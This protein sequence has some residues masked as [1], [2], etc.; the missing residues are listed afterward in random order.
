MTSIQSPFNET[1]TF[2]LSPVV[3]KS[4][5]VFLYKPTDK[6]PEFIDHGESPDLM[7]Y[8][9]CIRPASGTVGIY[10]TTMDFYVKAFNYLTEIYGMY[11]DDDDECVFWER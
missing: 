4:L 1:T 10:T 5:V 9:V 11:D 6:L 3:V 8:E 7:P 2:M